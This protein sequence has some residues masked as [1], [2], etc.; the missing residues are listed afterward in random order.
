MFSGLFLV[1]SCG[2]FP[3]EASCHGGL[4]TALTG[5]Q[6]GGLSTPPLDATCTH[7][8]C[9]KNGPPWSPGPHCCGAEGASDSAGPGRRLRRNNSRWQLAGAPQIDVRVK[10]AAASLCRW[11]QLEIHASAPHLGALTEADAPFKHLQNKVGGRGG[12]HL[13]S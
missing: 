6:T 10:P 3:G 5:D 4:T 11:P 13:A 8:Q 12:G 2:S 1:L 7:K 9:R